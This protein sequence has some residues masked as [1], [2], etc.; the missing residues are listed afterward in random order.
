M[1]TLDCVTHWRVKHTSVG[2]CISLSPNEIFIKSVEDHE[3]DHHELHNS[4]EN[5]LFSKTINKILDEP[6]KSYKAHNLKELDFVVGFNSSDTTFGWNGLDNG[7]ML[8]YS[9]TH[10]QYPSQG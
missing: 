4:E 6:E 1:K 7:L 5:T 9:D 10:E 8:Y 3:I 2:T